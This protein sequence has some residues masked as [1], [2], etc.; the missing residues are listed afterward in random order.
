WIGR[1]EPISRPA[2][3]PDITPFNFFLW[4][5]LQNIVHQ[6]TPTMPGNVKQRIIAAYAE[7]DIKIITRVRVSA[8]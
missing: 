2:H 6:E 1:G 8:I 5:T 3:S 7:I 4:G